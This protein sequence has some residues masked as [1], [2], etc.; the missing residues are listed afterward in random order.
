MAGCSASLQPASRCCAHPLSWLKCDVWASEGGKENS[1]SDQSRGPGSVPVLPSLHL[2]LHSPST[3]GCQTRRDPPT[4]PSAWSRA[5]F[6][7]ALCPYLTPVTLGSGQ[8]PGDLVARKGRQLRPFCSGSSTD[9]WLL[10]QEGAPGGTTPQPRLE[11]HHPA[12]WVSVPCHSSVSSAQQ[13]W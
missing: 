2:A 9:P 7:L 12:V 13:P 1:S 4:Q 6:C 11:S 10:Y 3:L 8:Q 5:S